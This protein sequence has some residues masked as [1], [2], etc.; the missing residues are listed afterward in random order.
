M[1]QTRTFDWFPRHD[2]ESR[3]YAVRDLIGATVERKFTIWQCGQCLDQ[4]QEG[5]CVGHGFTND[6]TA[7]PV[8][9]D[10][11]VEHFGNDDEG[12]PW[13]NDAQAFAFALYDWCRRHDEWK[14]Q[15]HEGTSVL[16]GAKG[17]KLLGL[18]LEYRWAF[19]VD[20]VIDTICA[21]G[22]V[23]L[24]IDWHEG[25]Y[26]APNGE[27]RVSGP[28]VGGHC[29]LAVGYDPAHKWAN[30]TVSP[31]IA[32]YNSWGEGWGIKGLAWISVT[33][34]ALL[35]SQDGEACVPVVRADPAVV[36]PE[37]APVDP[38]PTPDDPA[39]VPDPDPVDPGPSPRAPSWFESL[40]VWLWKALFG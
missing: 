28:K 18:L 8:P 35:L 14:D 29:I 6:A 4:G 27:L 26:D 30:G 37:P 38:E 40:I 10:F 9:V 21:H 5:A 1:T 24:G 16:T 19:G 7:E 17:M 25:M 22:P 31:A 20:D 23:V 15:P 3:N 2:P 32:L 13:P 33:D 12:H 36:T 11:T 34:L 39:P